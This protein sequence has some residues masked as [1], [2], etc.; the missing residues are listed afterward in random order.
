MFDRMGDVS[1]GLV[2]GIVLMLLFNSLWGLAGGVML[3]IFFLVAPRSKNRRT[4]KY[5]P[6]PR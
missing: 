4:R 2:F 6:Q 1:I 5:I 3:G